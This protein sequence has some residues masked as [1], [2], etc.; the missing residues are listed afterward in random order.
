V[1]NHFS[2]L[3]SG[4]EVER[5]KPNPDIYLLAVN[6]L[7][8]SPQACIAFEDSE[9][10]ARAAIAAGLKI[11]VVPDLLQPSDYVRAHCHQVV[12]SLQDWLNAIAPLN[13][14]A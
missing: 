4:Q 3:T 1:L 7:G 11:V 9:M 8:L 2:H 10:G 14:M 13:T 5:G 12:E 6:K